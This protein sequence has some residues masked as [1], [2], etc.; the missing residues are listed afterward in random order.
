M[1]VTELHKVQIQV[2]LLTVLMVSAAALVLARPG[3]LPASS[4]IF[5]ILGAVFM[6]AHWWLLGRVVGSLAGGQGLQTAVW[7][8]LSVFPVAAALAVVFVAAGLDR[9]VPLAAAIG[10]AGVPAAVTVYCLFYGFSY[11]PRPAGRKG[12]AHD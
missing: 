10:V 4:L 3:R 2:T 9:P 5:M 6:V 8:L 7:G 1:K 12:R 11:L